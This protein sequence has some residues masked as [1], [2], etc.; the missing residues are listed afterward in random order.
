M[1]GEL[2]S[3]LL[4]PPRCVL[5]DE[6][7]SP[8]EAEKRIHKTCESKLYPII[9]PVCMHCV[10]PIRNDYDVVSKKT[11]EQLQVLDK[12]KKVKGLDSVLEKY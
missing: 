5:C 3:S 7:L 9:G 12:L 8:E 1:C 4:F 11:I 10:R 2:L 6:I